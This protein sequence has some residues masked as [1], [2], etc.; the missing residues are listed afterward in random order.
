LALA[1]LVGSF[2]MCLGVAG[3]LFTL[4]DASAAREIEAAVVTG[5]QELLSV[6]AVKPLGHFLAGHFFAIIGLP[7]GLFGVWSVVTV[8]RERFPRGAYVTAAVSTLAYVLGVAW[9][10]T[11]GM[12]GSALS[13]A[14]GHAQRAELAERLRPLVLSTTVSFYIVAFTAFTVIFFQLLADKKLPR[15]LPWLS[16][17]PLHIVGFAAAALLPP[18]P[19]IFL[20]FALSNIVGALFY[21]IVALLLFSGSPARLTTHR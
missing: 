3:D 12:A 15:W 7:L 14:S 19:G 9:H 21:L 10:T 4:Y 13:G 5:R 1:A 6:L 16:P 18:V 8:I 20:Q 2:G 11:L 17:L